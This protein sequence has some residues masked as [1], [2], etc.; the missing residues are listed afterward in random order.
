MRCAE[1]FALISGARNLPG[2]FLDSAKV[3]VAY[4]DYAHKELEVADGVESVGTAFTN[5]TLTVRGELEQKRRG[6]ITGRLG[7]EGFH[8][9]FTSVGAEA[10]APAVTLSSLAAFVYEEA[11]YDRFRLQFGA[12][13]ERNAYS[14]DPR[15]PDAPAEAPA[16]RDRS[17]NSLSGSFGVHTNL[18][19]HGAFVVNLSAASRA[20]ALEELYNFG[21]HVGNLAFEVG[22]PDLVVERTLG[23]DVS[24]R[25]RAAQAKGEVNVFAYNI[26]NFVFLDFTGEEEDGLRVANYLQADSRFLGM[27]L[28]GEWQLHPM[29]HLHAGAS[30][31]R[32]TLKGTGEFLPRIPPFSARVEL[33]VPWRRLT[34]NPEVVFTARQNNVFRDETPTAGSTIVGLGATYL[35]GASHA[36]HTLALKAYN[37]TNEEYHLHNS[38]I[39]DFAAEMG[40]GVKLTYSVKFF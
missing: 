2:G 31:V 6:R 3:T 33:E 5:D 30:Y 21:P 29:L 15:S 39:K 14:V 8:R 35:F 12:R 13:A 10:L 25:S 37:L 27:E 19:S 34:L 28:S 9:D 26:S 38:L 17:F 11:A 32:A 40:R 16:V 23:V 18:G 4:T 7:A 22:N 1:T 20:P 24:L 36:T